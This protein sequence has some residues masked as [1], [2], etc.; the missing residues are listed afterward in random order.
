[1]IQ[2]LHHVCILTADVE[3][4]GGRLH[5][6]LGLP[7]PPPARVV[8]GPTLELRTAMLPIGNGTYLQL[9][10]PHSGPGVAELAAAGE[11]ALFEVAFKVDSAD[12]AAKEAANRG[13]T[14]TS[15][16]GLPLENGY[17]VAGSGSRYL[18]LPSTS[19]GGVRVELIEPAPSAG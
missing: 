14:P 13:I 9:L 11:G 8:S 7:L 16:S 10:E 19:T 3:A 1:L 15:L 6:A 5:D 12:H 4:L 17:A 18:Y 2:Q